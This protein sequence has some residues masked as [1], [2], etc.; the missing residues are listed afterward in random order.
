MATTKQKPEIKPQKYSSWLQINVALA[1]LKAA[2]ADHDRVSAK[3]DERLAAAQIAY[4][5]D[6]EQKAI[7]IQCIEQGIEAFLHE[8]RDELMG[9]AGNRS[10]ELENG[11]VGL[12]WGPP[13]L[14]TMSK[15]TFEKV[16]DRALSLPARLRD[17]FVKE[18]PSLDKKALLKA[19]REDAITEEV[20][21]VLG[22]DAR[23]EEY[24]VIEPA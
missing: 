5:D 17:L 7:Q 1:E 20:R 4:G 24:A 18:A 16:L 21:R 2:R 10:L 13:K 8:R 11:R 12:R 22:V 3:L 14:V 15:V 6:A 23:Q 19:I 9:E